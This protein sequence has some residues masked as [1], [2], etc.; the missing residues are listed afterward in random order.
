MT[1]AGTA[2]M[3][4][5]L[6]GKAFSDLEQYLP[7]NEVT[8]ETCHLLVHLSSPPPTHG[9]SLTLHQVLVATFQSITATT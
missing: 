8:A 4:R 9:W 1:P 5:G 6:Y 2:F 7:T 3:I